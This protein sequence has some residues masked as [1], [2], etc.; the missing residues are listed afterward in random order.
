[1]VKIHANTKPSPPIEILNQLVYYDKDQG[2]LFWKQTKGR[3]IADEP[4]LCIGS[5]GHHIIQINGKQYQVSRIIWFMHY[6]SDAE[7]TIDH[8]DTDKLNDHISNLR[9]ATIGQNN[10]NVAPRSNNKSGIRGLS[11][12]STRLKWKASVGLHGK[13]ISLGR[14]KGK[15]LAIKAIKEARSKLQKEFAFREHNI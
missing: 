8:K 9:L 6:G 15:I 10:C 14:F 3:M 5:N 2:C 12:D 11:F 4:C 7:C 1:M 13:V